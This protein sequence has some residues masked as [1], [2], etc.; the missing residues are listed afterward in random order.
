[1][2]LDNTCK[3]FHTWPSSASKLLLDKF[4]PSRMYDQVGYNVHCHNHDLLQPS[5]THSQAHK[6]TPEILHS[7]LTPNT[8]SRSRLITPNLIGLNPI[9]CTYL[10]LVLVP[11]LSLP[12]IR[13]STSTS[14]PLSDSL[15]S[16]SL[17][18]LYHLTLNCLSSSPRYIL[19]SS[20]YIWSLIPNLSWY[21]SL[22]A[23]SISSRTLVSS[24]SVW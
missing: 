14:F 23:C 2:H 22:S 12:H 19:C 11:C 16:L 3:P 9:A 4:I 15:S 1:M 8:H 10:S 5:P 24:P 20:P 6:L 17:S 13:Y 18:T 21:V 7:F